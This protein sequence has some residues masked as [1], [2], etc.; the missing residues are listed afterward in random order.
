MTNVP[1]PLTHVPEGI[2][3]TGHPIQAIGEPYFNIIISSHTAP[4]WY[5]LWLPKVAGTPKQSR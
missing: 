1:L 2:R 3:H 5:F 4:R